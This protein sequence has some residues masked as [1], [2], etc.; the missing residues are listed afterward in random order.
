MSITLIRNFLKFI[1]SIKTS[2][3]PVLRQLYGITKADVR[4]TTG[5]NLRNILIFYMYMTFTMVWQSRPSTWSYRT[6]TGGG[7][8]SSRRS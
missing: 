7:S 8:P 6:G 2:N 3:K 4:T 1:T 5:S